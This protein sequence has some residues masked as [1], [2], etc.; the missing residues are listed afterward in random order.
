MNW[1]H[2][3]RV[4]RTVA[5]M[6]ALMTWWRLWVCQLSGSSRLLTWRRQR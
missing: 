3:V 4:K 1:A 5:A 6:F 2:S